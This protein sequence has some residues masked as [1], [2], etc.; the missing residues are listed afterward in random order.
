[1][2]FQKNIS[3][4]NITDGTSQTILIAECPEGIH[5]QW[6]SVGN[7]FD[8]SALINTPAAFAPQYVFWDYGQEI[9]S[10]H[11]GGATTL[12]ADGSVHFL[13]ETLDNQT[14]AALCSRAGKELLT[15]F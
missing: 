11:R 5:S 8:Q 9:N 10:Y 1:M 14:L 15:G 4:A 12:F 7:L 3:I 6:M 13:A 2:I